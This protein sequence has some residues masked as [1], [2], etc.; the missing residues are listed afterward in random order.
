[1]ELEKIIC[2]YF[3]SPSGCRFG[4]RCKFIHEELSLDSLEDDP[5]PL[6]Q[7]LPISCK[8]YQNGDC[9]YG[10]DCRYRH[11]DVDEED[12][13]DGD[14]K[15]AGEIQEA[16][17]TTACCVCMEPIQ[18]YGLLSG[19]E[20]IFCIACISAWRNEAKEKKRSTD[21]LRAKR[22]CPVC[23]QHSDFVIPSN[24]WVTGRPKEILFE[25]R[26]A[27]RKVVPCRDWVN[28]KKCKCVVLLPLLPLLVLLF[29]TNCRFGGHC[30]YA[31][32]DKNGKDCKPQQR[33]EEERRR[34]IRFEDDRLDMR[35]LIEMLQHGDGLLYG[36][37]SDG[38]SYG[39]HL[40][41]ED[42]DSDSYADAW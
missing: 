19:C 41:G 1:M 27:Q 35:R 24:V 33:E 22:G 38:D 11:D 3:R 34:Q 28:K 31:H 30:H 2:I 37:E 26:L 15:V 29:L 16:E 4:A 39:N 6:R 7:I 17:S 13:E 8:F 21:E 12:E 25:R 20:H 32:L 5:T 42:Y 18:T 10:D 9:R 23:R 40:Y 14:C 36:D